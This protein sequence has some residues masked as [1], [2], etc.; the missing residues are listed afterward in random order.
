MVSD[1]SILQTEHFLS[2]TTDIYNGRVALIEHLI[3]TEHPVED[4]VKLWT[5]LD[6][7]SWMLDSH[8]VTLFIN[9]NIIVIIN[10]F[11]GTAWLEDP[12]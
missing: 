12:V 6:T 3:A 11:S 5:T 8:Q 10:T 2:P 7:E 9:H 1:W 4:I